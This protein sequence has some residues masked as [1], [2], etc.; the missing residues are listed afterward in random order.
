M[1][2]FY[3]EL[4]DFLVD[5]SIEKKVFGFDENEILAC[6][7]KYGVKFP[8]AYRLFLSKMAKSKLRIYDNQDYSIDGISYAHETSN[9]LLE[10]NNKSLCEE[11]FPFSQ[12]QGYN[13]Y[14]FNL[15]YDNP[16]VY[17]YLDSRLVEME[18]VSY[19]KEYSSFIEWICERVELNLIIRKK[20]YKM[21]IEHLLIELKK[22][23]HKYN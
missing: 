4:I 21:E 8:K 9:E 20:L 14:Y 3:Q 10:L 18:E 13:F 17:R 15:S 5:N 7:Q 11:S 16:K 6:E 23:K 1:E 2:K 12:W 19:L 22:L